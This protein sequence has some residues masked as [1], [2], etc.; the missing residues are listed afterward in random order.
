MTGLDFGSGEASPPGHRGL[1]LIRSGL[2]RE[3]LLVHPFVRTERVLDLVV[4]NVFR[5]C[6]FFVIGL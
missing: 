2:S 5:C 1:R 4:L 3:T 6:G